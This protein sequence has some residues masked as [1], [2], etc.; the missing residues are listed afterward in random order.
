MDCNKPTYLSSKHKVAS[1]SIPKKKL[2]SGVIS[3][4]EACM[5]LKDG[6]A[7][8]FNYSIPYI[9]YYVDGVETDTP[10]IARGDSFTNA[11]CY[12]EG[13]ESTYAML[14][15]CMGYF[16]NILGPIVSP[17]EGQC[18]SCENDGINM[19]TIVTHS[20]VDVRNASG[21]VTYFW[22][23][24]GCSLCE[25][26]GTD[27]IEISTTGL[28]SINISVRCTVTDKYTTTV[29]ESMC[30][31]KRTHDDTGDF[32]LVPHINLK[33]SPNLVPYTGV[34]K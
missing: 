25:G 34:I 8:I 21:E 17:I 29:R 22:E 9:R 18:G 26:Q 10:T 4:T 31:H 24:A 11:D 27:T 23:V 3:T 13:I 12:K 33:P 5:W 32:V 6:N 7:A 15:Q 14:L 28:Y 19:C 16:R 2:T 30:I 1:R 20:S